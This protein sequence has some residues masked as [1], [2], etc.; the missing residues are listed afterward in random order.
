MLNSLRKKSLSISLPFKNKYIILDQGCVVCGTFSS[1]SQ[2]QRY[3]KNTLDTSF[4]SPLFD[5]RLGGVLKIKK[6]LSNA[7]KGKVIHSSFDMI[8]CPRGEYSVGKISKTPAKNTY[9]KG[10]IEYPFLLGETEVTQELYEAVTGIRTKS[11]YKATKP[12]ANV[13]WF[14]AVFFCNSLSKLHRLDT[15]YEVSDMKYSNHDYITAGGTQSWQSIVSA[16]VLLDFKKNGYRLPLE[17]EWE[18]AAKA[19]TDNAWFGTNSA[20]DVKYYGWYAGNTG[21]ISE[22]KPVKKKLPNEWGFYDMLGNV[23]EWCWDSFY[24]TRYSTYERLQ[25]GGCY[26]YY[27]KATLKIEFKAGYTPGIKSDTI[28]FRLA[29][30]ILQTQKEE[31]E[32]C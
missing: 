13:T 20:S 6:Q 16:D 14:D 29:R 18:Y 24:N 4:Y 22:A 30:T 26:L 9:R 5:F 27:D 25:K 3:K 23:R 21:K 15:C 19:G 17:K 12:V 11:D 31:V 2:A 32:K 28:G 8:F 1:W 10:V 7:P